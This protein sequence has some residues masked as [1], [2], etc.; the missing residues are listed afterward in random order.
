M[1]TGSRSHPRLT[2]EGIR[3][4]LAFAAKA[5]YVWRRVKHGAFAGVPSLSATFR[6]RS[7]APGRTP[8]A[9]SQLPAFPILRSPPCSTAPY[10]TGRNTS[11]MSLPCSGA[12]E[13]LRL[14]SETTTLLS[15]FACGFLSVRRFCAASTP[16]EP[17]RRKTESTHNKTITFVGTPAPIRPGGGALDRCFF[18]EDAGGRPGSYTNLTRWSPSWTD[19]LWLL[20]PYARIA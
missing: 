6:M 10:L 5:V 18:R 11:F 16:L 15:L 13:T 9:R 17:G 19:A 4:G 3:A 8:G 12:G 14:R 2:E 20:F 7:A 1:A